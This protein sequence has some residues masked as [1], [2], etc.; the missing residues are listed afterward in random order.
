MHLARIPNSKL[1]LAHAHPY[2]VDLLGKWLLLKDYQPPF[3]DESVA[4]SRATKIVEQDIL[5]SKVFSAV[6][7]MDEEYTMDSESVKNLVF[8]K[9]PDQVR[10][11]PEAIKKGKLVLVPF[12]Y[13]SNITSKTV[14]HGAVSFGMVGDDS[15]SIAPIAMFAYGSKEKNFKNPDETSICAYFWVATTSSKDDANMEAGHVTAS[16]GVK[17]PVLKNSKVIPPYTKLAKYVEP[18]VVQKTSTLQT[19]ADN[20]AAAS[21]KA[22]SSLPTPAAK[23][24]RKS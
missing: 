20:G 3:V 2:M 6:V 16:N 12:V 8:W 10:T 23:R 13:M 14:T 15:A 5:R 24:S 11:G 7:E 1:G 21:T 9:K 22:A 17:V 19:T 18:Q 4:E